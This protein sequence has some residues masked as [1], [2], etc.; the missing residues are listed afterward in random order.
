MKEWIKDN[1]GKAF[2]LFGL[3]ISIVSFLVGVY[4]TQ[5]D[6][7]NEIEKLQIQIQSL[8]DGDIWYIKQQ[9]SH[10]E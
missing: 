5:K 3:I 10:S 9:L 6:L 8:K 2:S 1:L 7:G 4:V